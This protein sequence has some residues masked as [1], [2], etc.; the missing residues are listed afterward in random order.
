MHG[1]LKKLS[2]KYSFS[3]SPG[4]IKALDIG[5]AHQR[6]LFVAGYDESIK[7]FDCKRFKNLGAVDGHQASILCLRSFANT[8][9]SG[10]EEGKILVW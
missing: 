1:T 4:C 10:D 9:F 8:L 6:F 5:H 7:I 2:V 3:A